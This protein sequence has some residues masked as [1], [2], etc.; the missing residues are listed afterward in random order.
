MCGCAVWPSATSAARGRRVVV[1]FDI[2]DLSP[3]AISRFS[4]RISTL[5]PA[6][7]S[8]FSPTSYLSPRATSRISSHSLSQPPDLS[9]RATFRFSS[10]S[11]I[12][13]RGDISLFLNSYL[14]P[15]ATSRFSSEFPR[16]RQRR[17]FAFSP[18]P[19]CRPWRHLAFRQSATNRRLL[20]SSRSPPHPA[21]PDGSMTALQPRTCGT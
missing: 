10:D 5:S 6:A 18:N 13:A 20:G 1:V 3:R 21:A 19:R 2:Y 16:C 15:V 9:P 7:T 8:R 14:S 12:V 17:H 4:A 11:H